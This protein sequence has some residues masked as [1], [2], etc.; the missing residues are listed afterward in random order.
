MWGYGHMKILIVSI[1]TKNTVIWSWMIHPRLNMTP[2]VWPF[3]RSGNFKI[4]V[5][6]RTFC[7]NQHVW[8]SILQYPLYIVMVAMN[9]NKVFLLHSQFKGRRVGWI[10]CYGWQ[11]SMLGVKLSY[12]TR[13]LMHLLWLDIF[14]GYHTS[15]AE[16]PKETITRVTKTEDADTTLVKIKSVLD[17]IEDMTKVSPE[18]KDH[19]L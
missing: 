11:T 19:K 5:L 14:E 3:K 18:F 17:T 15:E 7:H 10:S 12:R 13:D 16:W 9:G 8:C 1:I 4:C 6:P 2:F